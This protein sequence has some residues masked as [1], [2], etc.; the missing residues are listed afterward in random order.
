MGISHPPFTPAPPAAITRVLSRF[1]RTALA[2]FIEVAIDLLDVAEGD[3][4]AED[5]GDEEDSE[6]GDQAWPEWH[7][8]RAEQ[9]RVSGLVAGHEDDEEDDDSGDCSN[10]DEP[11]GYRTSAPFPG[12]G[13]PISDPGG[14]QTDER[15][16]DHADMGLT[17]DWPIDQRQTLPEAM[18]LASDRAG[19][20]HHCARIQRTRCIK[21]PRGRMIDGRWVRHVLKDDRDDGKRS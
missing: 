6:G 15:E 21:L 2:G 16:E 3:T 5:N 1:D 17:P 20:L 10:E 19:M 11:N 9:K 4:D 8:L 7:T 12:A 13:C 18:V 14:C